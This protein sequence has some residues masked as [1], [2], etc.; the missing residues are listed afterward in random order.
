MTTPA[1]GP[2]LLEAMTL[3]TQY[4]DEVLLHTA[5]DT[6]RAI[7]RRVFGVLGPVATVPRVVHD[8]ISGSIYAGLG[9]G[10]AAGGAALRA[11]GGGGPRLAPSVQS[12]IAGVVGDRL[13]DDAHPM[14]FEM[15]VR[16]RGADVSLDPAQLAAAFPTATTKVVVLLHGLCETEA[17]FSFRAAEGPTYAQTLATQGWTPVFV[18]YNS[19]LSVR[20]NGAALA[21]L[22]QGLVEAWPATLDRLALLGHSMGGLVVRAAT[23]VAGDHDWPARVTDMVT[24]GAPHLGAPLAVQAMHG[25][26]LLQLFPEAAAFGRIIDHRSVGIRDLEAVLD[27]PNLDHA[28]YR[29]VSAQMRGVAGFLLGD[30]LVRRGSAYG[31][32]RRSELFP[33]AE[34][35]HLPDTHHFGLLNH[36]EVHTRLKEWLA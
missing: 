18:R 24:L 35:L 26:R 30:L 33:D 22:L 12:A 4:G 9:A 25:G 6:H 7:A 27:M 21:S 5:R 23:S 3:A 29:L 2:G 13:R 11:A 36:P 10:L 19:G 34:V 15:S 20:E 14:H 8:G 31:R 16:L 28:R 1:G 17:V 32:S